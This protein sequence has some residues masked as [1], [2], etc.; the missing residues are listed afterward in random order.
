MPTQIEI[1]IEKYKQKLAVMEAEQRTLRGREL[2]RLPAKY[3]Y[4]TMAEF[5]EACRK[6]DVRGRFGRL[7]PGKI[8][9]KGPKKKYRPKTKITDE[10]RQLVWT[11]RNVDH[12]KIAEIEYRV[13]IAQT[14]INRILKQAPQSTQPPSE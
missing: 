1:K 10:I 2:I 13:G 7:K 6:A 9:P 11:M 12:L 14:T 8:E 4:K 3:G 5:I